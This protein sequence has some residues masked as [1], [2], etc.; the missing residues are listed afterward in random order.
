MPRMYP[1]AGMGCLGTLEHTHSLAEKTC[2]GVIST[3]VFTVNS[4][5]V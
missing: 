5:L 4:K 3:H 1:N 2:A